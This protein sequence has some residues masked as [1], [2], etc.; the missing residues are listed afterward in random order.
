M[1]YMQYYKDERDK[2]IERAAA[3]KQ[4]ILASKKETDERAEA[5]A[6]NIAPLQVIFVLKDNT[7]EWH[8]LM[9]VM[10]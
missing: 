3:E 4:C 5:M 6:C 1:L 8:M 7:I 9:D 10:L 2:E